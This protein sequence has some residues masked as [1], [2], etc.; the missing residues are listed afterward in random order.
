MFKDFFALCAAL[1]ILNKRDTDN[2]A[3]DD[4]DAEPQ[5]SVENDGCYSTVQT[6]CFTAILLVIFVSCATGA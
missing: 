3:D 6:L 2:D 4:A 5:G 1:T